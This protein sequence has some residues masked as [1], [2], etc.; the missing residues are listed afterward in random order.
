MIKGSAGKIRLSGYDD[1]FGSN[2]A[3]DEGMVEE[4]PLTELYEFKNHP[5][6]VLDDEKMLETVETPGQQVGGSD[7]WRDWGDG[8]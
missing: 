2:H 8:G 7:A 4:I 5:F 6:R 3:S 1:L